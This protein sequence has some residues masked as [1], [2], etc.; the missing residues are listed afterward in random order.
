[1]QDIKNLLINRI[2][3]LGSQI[4]QHNANYNVLLGQ[5]G[6]AEHLLQEILKAEAAANAPAPEVAAPGEEQTPPTH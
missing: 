3:A 5:K 4:T 2:V 1:M 6:E